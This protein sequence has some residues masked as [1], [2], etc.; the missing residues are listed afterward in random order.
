M[1]N[2]KPGFQFLSYKLT[3]C[4]GKGKFGSVWSATDESADQEVAIKFNGP[5]VPE[6]ILLHESDILREISHCESFPNYIGN[7]KESGLAYLIQEKFGVSLRYYMESRCNSPIKLNKTAK[8]G[9]K[10]LQCIQNFHDSGYVHRN[11]KPSNF[12]FR[13]DPSQLKMYLIDYKLAKRWCS[14]E[15]EVYPPRENVGFRGTKVYASI[16]SHEGKD[17]S[18]RDDLFSLMYVLDELCAPPLPWSSQR[19]A[20]IIYDMKK[21]V[22]ERWIFSNYM[23]RQF[24]NFEEH[25]RSLKF[26]EKPDYDL[27][28]DLLKEVSE[29]DDYDSNPLNSNFILGLEY[30]ESSTSVDGSWSENFINPNKNSDDI[31]DNKNETNCC[32][33]C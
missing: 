6:S 23:P 31:D 24:R 17:L 22:S 2:L 30:I 20:E 8:I 11:I 29:M 19:D 28:T 4:L 25:V 12:V 10:M 32:V 5:P 26:E 18:R 9:I 16:N 1:E 33:I 21:Q 15:G 7:G 14:P 3:K 27:L 13:G